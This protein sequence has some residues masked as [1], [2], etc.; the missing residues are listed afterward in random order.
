MPN[1]HHHHHLGPKHSTKY[2]SVF[3]DEREKELSEH[4][5]ATVGADFASC[6]NHNPSY[7][8]SEA[9]Q[10]LPNNTS[11]RSSGGSGGDDSVCTFSGSSVGASSLENIMSA[12]VQLDLQGDSVTTASD[13]GHC[14]DGVD[15]DE[16][17]NLS[18]DDD[19]GAVDLD[20]FASKEM[21]DL[22][23]ELRRNLLQEE[24][25][26][27]GSGDG[28]RALQIKGMP[29]IGEIDEFIEDGLPLDLIEEL[30]RNARQFSSSM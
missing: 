8:S 9:T 19:L 15:N 11:S 30:D 1:H 24:R 10:V 29:R 13:S 26:C 6:N 25:G 7:M 23:Q 21:A 14:E 22:L 12:A 27:D 5:P 18:G 3:T 28:S 4:V 20:S 2:D 17:A 16:C